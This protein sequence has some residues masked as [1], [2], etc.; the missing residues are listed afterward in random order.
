M[1]KRGLVP[2]ARVRGSCGAG[3]RDAPTFWRRLCAGCAVAVE[4]SAR[5]AYGALIYTHLG[6]ALGTVKGCPER[7]LSVVWSL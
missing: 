4:T 6:I 5:V 1:A 2:L 3:M 7:V